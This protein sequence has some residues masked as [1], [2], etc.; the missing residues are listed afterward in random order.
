MKTLF[1]L[2]PGPL[3]KTNLLL[4][5]AALPLILSG[6]L[7]PSFGFENGVT[8][9]GEIVT[10]TRTVSNFDEV[11]LDG[12]GSVFITGGETR[13]IDISGSGEVKNVQK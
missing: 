1:Q 10:E 6:C 9:S 13:S 7:N 3:C 4:L 8:G 2:R 12:S 11:N 5:V